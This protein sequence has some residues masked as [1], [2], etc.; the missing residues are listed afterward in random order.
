MAAY[1]DVKCL[2]AAA[3]AATLLSW[4]K[5]PSRYMPIDETEEFVAA[6]TTPAELQVWLNAVQ[7]GLT[8]PLDLHELASSC[9]KYSD[10]M[11]AQLIQGHPFMLGNWDH[12]AHYIVRYTNSDRAFARFDALREKMGQ[13][14]WDWSE[15][16]REAGRL[17]PMQYLVQRGHCPAEYWFKNWLKTQCLHPM[18]TDEQ[19][20]LATWSAW[21]IEH[22][23]P[24]V[25]T[26]PAYEQIYPKPLRRGANYT[27]YT[28]PYKWMLLREHMPFLHIAAAWNND[29][30]W[31]PANM[32]ANPHW[33]D[34]A[35]L[36]RV[37]YPKEFQHWCARTNTSIPLQLNAPNKLVWDVACSLNWSWSE[38]LAQLTSA[39][40]SETAVELPP[41]FEGN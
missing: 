18:S 39:R 15:A 25:Q 33:C 13:S 31:L 3:I 16:S 27:N 24:H 38:L 10:R 23:F 2:P 9:N 35:Y 7:Q 12:L 36:L 37:R 8:P 40:V 29:Y 28:L 1:P 19:K 4:K 26:Y 21:M 32:P 14:P 30:A 6:L 20:V 5:L 22:V 17:A 34:Y 11:W 41:G